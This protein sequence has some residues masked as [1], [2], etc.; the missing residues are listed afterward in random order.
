MLGLEAHDTATPLAAEVHVV[1][2]A[3]AEVLGESLELG[4]VFLVDG[5]DG[6]A[7]G[8]L[9]V[10]DLA[11]A[12]LTLDDAEGDILLAA[13]GG[14]PEDELDGVDIMGDDDELGLLGLDEL[15]NVVDTV[16]HEVGLLGTG[17][18][19][20]NLA[21]GDA[22]EALR[23][24]GLGLGLVAAHETEELGGLVLVDAV[25]ELVDGRG[26]LFI[27]LWNNKTKF[28][29]DQFFIEFHIIFSTAVWLLN[30]CSS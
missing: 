4:L 15:D 9:L 20:G 18:L 11:E 13:E 29:L 17:V 12:A 22:L 26:D 10:D 21:L 30:I 19:A 14:Q 5:G 27:F 8:G 7:G 16:L 24:L 28:D 2:E 6:G 25:V 1:I 23:L 3:G